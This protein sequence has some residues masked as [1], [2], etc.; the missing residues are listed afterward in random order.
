[1]VKYKR[2]LMSDVTFSLPTI[3]AHFLKEVGAF[4]RVLL[5]MVGIS[6]GKGLFEHGAGKSV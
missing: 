1:M 2:Q 4:W 5:S 3:R 6:E